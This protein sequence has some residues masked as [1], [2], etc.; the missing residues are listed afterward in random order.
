[1]DNF[2]LLLYFLQIVN[3]IFW[4]QKNNNPLYYLLC[5][6]IIYTI[7]CVYNGGIIRF[8]KTIIL[9]LYSL[10]ILFCI[11]IDENKCND[12]KIVNIDNFYFFGIDIT[13]S[14]IHLLY[15]KYI[16]KVKNVLIK[17][18]SHDSLYADNYTII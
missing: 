4:S 8:L 13:L 6:E 15:L 12:Q 14:I 5:I 11:Y 10:M 16:I 3:V 7:Y 1:M 9:F 2:E 18:N 17:D